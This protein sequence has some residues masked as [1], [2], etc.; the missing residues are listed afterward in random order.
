M[1]VA[2]RDKVIVFDF[3][4]TISLGD[5]PV[6]SYARLISESLDGD[7][8]SQFLRTVEQGLEGKLDLDIDPVDGYELVRIL[9]R[10]AGVSDDARDDA[11]FASR[12]ELATDAAP[13]F[14]PRGLADFLALARDSAYLVLATNSPETRIADALDV[15]GVAESFD[16]VYTSVGKPGGLALIVDEWLARLPL[17]DPATTLLSVGDIWINDLEPAHARGASTALV[18]PRSDLAAQPTFTA[19]GLAEL[20]LTLNSWLDVPPHRTTSTTSLAHDQR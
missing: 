4:G 7:A 1:T 17:A 2:D 10:H 5:G 18:G 15:L 3:D 6:R 8:K 20:Y 16:E 9:S 14:A 12:A 19:T 11:F 13:V